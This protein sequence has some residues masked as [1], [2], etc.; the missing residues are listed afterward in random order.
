MGRLGDC[1]PVDIS[2]GPDPASPSIQVLDDYPGPPERPNIAGSADFWV[3][4]EHS[5]GFLLCENTECMK[6]SWGMTSWKVK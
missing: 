6:W 4:Y 3:V 2:L 5:Y 1:S